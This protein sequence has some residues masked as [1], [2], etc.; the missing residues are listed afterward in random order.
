MGWFITV[1]DGKT[2]CFE[3]TGEAATE[4]QNAQRRKKKERD[5]SE[6]RKRRSEGNCQ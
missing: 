6:A 5:R 1:T 4:T 3:T 2:R